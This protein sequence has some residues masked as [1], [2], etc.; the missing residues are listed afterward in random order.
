M[1][2]VTQHKTVAE[3]RK[4]AIHQC[5]QDGMASNRRPVEIPPVAKWPLV[6]LYLI[7]ATTICV[8]AYQWLR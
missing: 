7:L 8:A 3:A 2:K 1:A 4:A 6:T 5:W